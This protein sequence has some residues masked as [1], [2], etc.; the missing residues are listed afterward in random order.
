[1]SPAPTTPCGP[2]PDLGAGPPQ[3]RGRLP[4]PDGRR[5]GWAEWGPPDGEPVLLCPGAA[6]SRSLGFGTHLLTDLGVRLVSVDRPGL[7]VSDPQPGRTLTDWPHDVAALAAARGLGVPRMV[8]FSQGAPFALACAAHGVASAV[9]V[10]SGGGDM[11]DPGLADVLD[12][13]VRPL[14]E[15]VRIDPGRAER[16]FAASAGPDTLWEAMTSHCAG[17]DRALV[18]DPSFARACRRAVAEGFAQGPAGYARDAVLTLGRWPLDLRRVT[19]PVDLWYGERD[20]SPFHSHRLSEPLLSHVPTVRRHVVP[21]AGG[22][23]LWT[24]AEA[25]LKALV[26]RGVGAA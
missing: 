22:L 1:M 15:A 11:T 13:R 6:T 20:T 19:V 5:L 12:A 9:A 24:H 17:V 7:G 25:V 3:R 23:L 26:R 4:L 2:R 16:H 10:V 18:D 21:G 8:G 14:V